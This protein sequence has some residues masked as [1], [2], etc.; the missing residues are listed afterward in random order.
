M[1]R[2]HLSFTPYSLPGLSLSVYVTL[3][4]ALLPIA[5]AMARNV[6][7]IV[8]DNMLIDWLLNKCPPTLDGKEDTLALF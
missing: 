4:A 1:W 2:S 3:F 5:L 7:I 8:E 6:V